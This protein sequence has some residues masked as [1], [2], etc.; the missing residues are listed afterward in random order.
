M[1]DFKKSFGPKRSGFKG[2]FDRGP[3]TGG[4][5]GAPR[6]DDS[7]SAEMFE[8]TCASC[9]KTC[10]V[11]FRPNGKKPVYC[12]D[13]FAA[14]KPDAPERSSYR[15]EAPR[16]EHRHDAAPRYDGSPRADDGLKAEIVKLGIKLDT[17][18]GLMEGM[19]SAQAP[20]TPKSAPRKKVK[21]A[22]K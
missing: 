5:G 9:K 6:R 20:A 16:R 22:A 7:R 19:A 21:K 2:G 4:F 11:P 3:R 15:T 8:A 10:E 14:H 18:I 17:L 13:C 12:K 1:K